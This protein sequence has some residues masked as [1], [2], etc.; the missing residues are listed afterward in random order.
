MPKRSEKGAYRE[1][2]E[3]LWRHD[4]RRPRRTRIEIIQDLGR[5]T[6]KQIITFPSHV[7]VDEKEIPKQKTG[8]WTSVWKHGI[9]I[10]KSLE[11]GRFF[12]YD[13]HDQYL[14][15]LESFDVYHL[16][17]RLLESM[18]AITKTVDRRIKTG[19][20]M[21]YVIRSYKKTVKENS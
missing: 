5:S 4:K 21:R 3:R 18:D 10:I 15:E 1:H 14:G 11:T 16:A 19:R 20:T 6:E 9:K 12:M 8:L 2:Q 17:I 7:T 13:Q